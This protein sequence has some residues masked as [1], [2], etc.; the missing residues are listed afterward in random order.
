MK[1]VKLSRIGYSLYGDSTDIPGPEVENLAEELEGLGLYELPQITLGASGRVE[2]GIP[3]TFA[4][5]VIDT[6]IYLSAVRQA[7]FTMVPFRY[8]EEKKVVKKKRPK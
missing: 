1:T 3:V 8:V 4:G 5:K 7:G 6:S 2:L